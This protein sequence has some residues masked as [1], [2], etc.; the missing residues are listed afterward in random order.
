LWGS[1]RSTPDFGPLARAYDRLRPA[2]EGWAELLQALIADG[3]LLGRR[4]LDVGCGTGRIAVAL[5]KRGATVSGVDPSPEML[6]EARARG[7]GVVEFEQAPAEA[8]P[9]A[10]ASFERAVLRLVVH[11]VDRPRAFCEVARVLAPGG[12]IVIGTFRPEH[13]DRFWLN[14]YFPSIR[15]LDRR[16]FPSPAVLAEE[17]KRAG[18]TDLAWRP[19]TLVRHASRAEALERIRGRFI[20]TLRLVPDEEF[21]EGLA[22][23]ERE[24]PG[25]LDTALEWAIVTALRP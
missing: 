5:A 4:V 3:D 8:L 1:K 7:R 16:R 22:R 21:R 6:V 25:S 20:S 2:D 23:A 11:L 13:F 18:F 17:L 14:R 15:E 19:L 12:R 9:F 24:L 10:D